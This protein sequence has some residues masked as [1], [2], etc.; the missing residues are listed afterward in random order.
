MSREAFSRIFFHVLAAAFAAIAANKFFILNL[1][2]E[3]ADPFYQRIIEFRGEAPDQY[4]ILPLLGLK[5]LRLQFPFHHSVMILNGVT[6]FV[7][8][9][10]LWVLLG[11][12]SWQQKTTF[13]LLFCT[14]FIY[15]QYTGWRPDTMALLA[16]CCVLVVW[17][18]E[19]KAG[20]LRE[21]GFLLGLVALSFSR[22]DV[23]L[24]YAVFFGAVSLGNWPLRLLA[25]VIP[26]G[27]QALLQLVLFPDAPYYTHFFMLKDNLSGYYLVMNPATWLLAA[28]LVARGGEIISF[29]KESIR[30]NPYFYL[31]FTM[32]AAL[33]LV[34][35][36]L[37]EYR[38]Y[39]PFVPLF[40]LLHPQ[41]NGKEETRHL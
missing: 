4:R 35:G 11:S 15:T 23:A 41:Q 32:Y 33:V 38:L 34:T 10:C 5:L 29:I 37:N 39:L 22:A 14:L 31:V 18:K 8:L 3:A 7:V 9:E 20:G 36:R 30:K 25:F 27:I 1:E 12:R 16:L 13:N 24:A 2:A 19:G 26:I 28:L 40:L 17:M 21:G 6:A